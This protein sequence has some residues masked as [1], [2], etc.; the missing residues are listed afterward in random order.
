MCGSSVNSPKMSFDMKIQQSAGFFP[1]SVNLALSIDLAV[2]CNGLGLAT[3]V[4]CCLVYVGCI[5]V[6]L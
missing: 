1:Y 5:S 6:T 2:N 3:Q 4:Q